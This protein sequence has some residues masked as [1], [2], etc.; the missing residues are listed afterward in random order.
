MSGDFDNNFA[1][2]LI[3]YKIYIIKLKLILFLINLNFV[4]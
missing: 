3:K 2:K 1:I 4:T